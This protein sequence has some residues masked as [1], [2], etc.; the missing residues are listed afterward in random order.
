MTAM[1]VLMVMLIATLIK[2][3]AAPRF[4]C[5][6]QGLPHRP[7]GG[8][9]D[10]LLSAPMARRFTSRVVAR[11]TAQLM[12]SALDLLRRIEAG[13][14]RGAGVDLCARRS[15][16]KRPRRVRDADL[17]RARRR[18]AAWTHDVRLR[19]CRSCSRI[20]STP[21]TCRPNT[22]R[23]FTPATGREADAA[24]VMITQAGGIAFADRDHRARQ[25]DPGKTRIW[26]N[27]DHARRF[28]RAASAAVAA[29][30]APIATGSQTGGR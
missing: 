20:F 2:H 1:M 15:P 4:R 17:D 10:R 26:H 22:A 8:G 16:R 12:L 21:P 27:P 18:S 5:T 14:V 24:L 23:R 29:G 7:A 11:S 30:F 6:D 13:A 25:G 19:G 9:G 28:R 3:R